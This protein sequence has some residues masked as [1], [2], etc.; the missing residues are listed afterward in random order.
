MPRG[1]NAANY[2]VQLGTIDTGTTQKYIVYWGEE[3]TRRERA[4][5][6]R[7]APNHCNILTPTVSTPQGEGRRRRQGDA[8]ATKA[9]EPT[10]ARTRQQQQQQ[11]TRR[12]AVHTWPSD[13]RRNRRSFP[14]SGGGGC[15]CCRCLDRRSCS[16]LGDCREGPRLALVTAHD[17]RADFLVFKPL[18][19]RTE[20]QS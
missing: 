6:F 18:L 12:R 1:K 3:A 14:S 19:Q 15:R 2:V 7:A 17:V 9:T 16:I 10:R 13:Y 20:L 11:H 5:L 4:R 8:G